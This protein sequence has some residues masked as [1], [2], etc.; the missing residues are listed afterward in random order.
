MQVSE[1]AVAEGSEVIQTVGSR[2]FEIDEVIQ[3]L[4]QQFEQILVL[5][6]R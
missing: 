4:N 2:F 6:S 1:G 3:K 5:H